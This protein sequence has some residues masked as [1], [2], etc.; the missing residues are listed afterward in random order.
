MNEFEVRITDEE[1]NI[2]IFTDVTRM[3]VGISRIK[4]HRDDEEP[5]TFPTETTEEITIKKIR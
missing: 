5:F 1:G 4:I 2:D 3:K